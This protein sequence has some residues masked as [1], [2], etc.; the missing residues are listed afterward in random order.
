MLRLS[1]SAPKKQN[2]GMPQFALALNADEAAIEGIGRALRNHGRPDSR[3]NR[4]NQEKHRAS[5]NPQNENKHTQK[6][7]IGK[8]ND[9]QAVSLGWLPSG[10][11][12]ASTSAAVGGPAAASIA[13]SPPLPAAAP[14]SA[15]RGKGI[16]RPTRTRQ[17]SSEDAEAVLALYYN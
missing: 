17:A 3:P 12:A 7:P 2:R 16:N 1:A 11:G 6:T 9:A 5:A 4:S 10:T 8:G 13:S 14:R 15:I